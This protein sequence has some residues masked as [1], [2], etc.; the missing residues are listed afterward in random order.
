LDVIAATEMEKLDAEGV[1]GVDAAD[2]AAG[3]EGEVFDLEAEI[4][5]VAEV[6]ARGEIRLKEA[7]VE[8]EIEDAATAKV[9]VVN[10]EVGGTVTGVAR[11]AAALFGRVGH[12]HGLS[13]ADDRG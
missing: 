5:D 8:A 2:D 10:A 3:A 11:C 6:I 13:A 4:E 12:Q 7:T 1:V 9:P